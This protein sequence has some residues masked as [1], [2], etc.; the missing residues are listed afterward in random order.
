MREFPTSPH[1]KICPRLRGSIPALLATP[2]LAKA[3]IMNDS[4]NDTTGSSERG[5]SRDDG[6]LFAFTNTLRLS[7]RAKVAAEQSRG[8]SLSEIVVQVREMVRIAEEDARHP[9]RFR[10]KAGGA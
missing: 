8:L 3:P 9:R 5:D 1:C 4:P 2:S 10:R 6:G 7:V